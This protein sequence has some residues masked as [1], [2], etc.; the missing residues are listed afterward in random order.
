ML[1]MYEPQ[2]LCIYPF[3][4]ISCPSDV[5]VSFALIDVGWDIGCKYPSFD[6]NIQLIKQK[7]CMYVLKMDGHV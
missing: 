4:Q 7:V 5:K 3:L 1:P 6:S 2:T